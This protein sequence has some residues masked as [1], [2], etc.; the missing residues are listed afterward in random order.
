MMASAVENY[1]AGESVNLTAL[2]VGFVGD[3]SHLMLFKI[4][5]P[6]VFGFIVLV[7]IT[8][9]SLIIYVILSRSKMRT[10]INLLLLNLAISDIAFLTICGTF[11]VVHYALHVWPL[12][13]A[14][15]RIIQYLLYTTAY[16]TVYTLVAI[17]VVRFMTVVYFKQTIRLRNRRNMVILI[18][19]IWLTFLVSKIPILIVHGVSSLPEVNGTQ[20]IIVGRIEGQNLFASF[21][22]FAYALPLTVIATFYLSILIHIKRKRPVVLQN[23]PLSDERKKHVTKIVILVVMVFGFCWLPLHIHLL[24]AYYGNVPDTYVYK[25]LLLVW[26]SLIY[27]NSCFNP[28]IYNYVSQDFRNSFKEVMCCQ[29]EAEPVTEL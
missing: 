14:L 19:L 1:H 2:D 24:V 8:G 4:T 28:L 9:N 11:T 23:S 17:S 10:V 6:I 25:C 18:S 26:H 3:F 13:D 7:G 12:G 15:C 29:K 5:V 20:C 22:V 16:V 27:L 21:F